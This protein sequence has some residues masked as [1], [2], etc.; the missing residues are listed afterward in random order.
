[1]KILISG[2]CGFAGSTI[3]TTL[4]ATD[5]TLEISG[6]DNFIRPGSESNRRKLQDLGIKV[7][8]ADLRVTSDIEAL[9][10]ADWV[11]DA[12]ALPSVLA[13]VDGKSSSRQLLEHN[14]L[15]TV[16]LLEFCKARRAGFI[17]LSTSRVYSIPPL[18]ALPLKVVADA[19]QPDTTFTLPSGVGPQ[20]ITE[21]FASNPPLSLYGATKLSSE[22][23]ALEY[24][25]TY[26]FPVHI[27]RCGV[28]AG[29]GQF[30]QAEQ[31]IFSFWVHS[32]RGRRPL[33][34]IGFEGRGFQVRDCLHP[35]DVAQLIARQLAGASGGI[36]NVAGGAANAMSLAQLSAWCRE[37]FGP[38]E[39]AA[40]PRPRP[41]DVPWMVLDSELA[42]KTWDWVPTTPVTEILDEIARHAEAEPGWFD[43]CNP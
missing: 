8:H 13:G 33:R 22:L 25:A 1:M 6:F 23:L 3:A 35:R 2:I 20:G 4:R 43:L 18:A 21:S 27:N 16:N 17:L 29:A 31:G 28:L 34:Y 41:F 36:I 5:S 38:H 19:F 26:G 10:A 42:R 12:A 32:W 40:D 11:L 39:V 9:P 24:A 30:G 37:R 15:G 14:L 7:W